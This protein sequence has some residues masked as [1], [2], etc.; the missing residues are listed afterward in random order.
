MKSDCSFYH[1]EFCFGAFASILRNMSVKSGMEIRPE[2]LDG[3]FIYHIKRSF[4]KLFKNPNSINSSV[5]QD[6]STMFIRTLTLFNTARSAVVPSCTRDQLPYSILHSSVFYFQL[7]SRRLL[8]GPP[9]H[10]RSGQLPAPPFN[11]PV[12][13]EA[14]YHHL[15]TRMFLS[16][17]HQTLCR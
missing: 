17:F 16:V 5:G 7:F 12:V 9:G 10:Q 14:T 13:D 3:L 11:C 8:P 4:G 2:L 15:S 6:N 1:L